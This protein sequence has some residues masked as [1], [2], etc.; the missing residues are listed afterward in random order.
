MHY[1]DITVFVLKVIK[2]FFIYFI[3]NCNTIS[4]HSLLNTY[5]E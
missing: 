4:N 1:V 5:E 3:K 2:Y